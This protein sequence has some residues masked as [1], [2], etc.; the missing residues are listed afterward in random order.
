[1]Y[2]TVP[3]CIAAL[4]YVTT[5]VSIFVPTVLTYEIS[6]CNKQSVC[7]TWHVCGLKGNIYNTFSK[8]G[9]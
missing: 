2:S 6:I 8:Y 9:E 3:N 5:V 7:R 4:L 1:M